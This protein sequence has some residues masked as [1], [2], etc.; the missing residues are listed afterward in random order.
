MAQYTPLQLTALAQLMQNQ[1]LRTLPTALTTAI[2][3]YNATAVI[4]D[5]L[6][7]VVWYKQQSFFTEST[8]DALLS[9]GSGV[10]P[11]LGNS[12]PTSPLG[13]FA[14]IIAKYITY[15]S[16]TGT[17]TVNPAGFADLLE[18]AGNAYLGNSNASN[19]AQNFT[20]VQGYVDSTNSV[21]NSAANANSYLGPTFKTMDSLVT[22]GISEVNSD[23][24]N[25]GTDLA[26]Q[27]NLV[28]PKNVANFG[29]PAALLQQLAKL[30]NMLNGSLPGVQ[31][32][33]NAAGLTN[34]DIADLV[35]N[36]VQSLFNPNGL[37]AYD[38]DIL[39]KKA[40]RG[41]INVTGSDLVDV[42][43][44]F[45][46]KT[47]GITTMADLLNP[48]K[49]FPLS[50]TTFATPDSSGN[51]VPVY[52]DNVGTINADIQPIVAANLPAAS[53]CEELGKVIPPDQ[54]VAN[55]ALQVSF[56]QIS[57]FPLTTWPALAQAVKGYTDRTWNPN[58]YYLANDVVSVNNG[59]VPTFYQAQQDVLPGVNIVDTNFWKPTT[60]PCGLN[61]MV[62]LPD[63][64]A[65]TT[66][67]PAS[68][69]Q[70]F[71]DNVATGSGANGTLTIYDIIGLAVDYNNFAN[72]L[73]TV[74]STINT[75]DGLG[76][77]NTLKST[78]LAIVTSVNDAAVLGY[79]ATAN[80][81]ISTIAAAQPAYVSAMNTA[82]VYMANLLNK[83]FG[84]QNDAGVDYFLDVPAISSNLRA[85]V[86][87]LNQYGTM[88]EPGGPAEFLNQ[89]ADTAT[90]GGQ[91]M[92]GSLRAGKNA[93]CLGR[94]RILTN[95]LTVPN[96]PE[97]DPI[98]AVTPE[99]YTKQ[100][101]VDAL[102]L[103]RWPGQL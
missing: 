97:L 19:F 16:T 80:A 52:A 17:S 36:N 11:A 14:D 61:T 95:A 43:T 55:K 62:D 18:Q 50:F 40:Y 99:T 102:R 65:Q 101:C 21:I 34:K 67:I 68:V 44:V 12:V 79:I 83:E 70:Y 42:L 59:S 5:W 33:L 53:G 15:D 84:Y 75:L 26:N 92:V 82:W 39:Q 86:Q 66:P 41:L 38:F 25:F 29:T 94:A 56:Q 81:D 4:A 46:V 31:N 57:G 93:A 77:L 9:I 98:P 71:A 51:P 64:Q 27:G 63:I 37:S 23:F 96:E 85:F 103:N 13:S 7:A 73:N 32:A 35:N 49:T 3:N 78:Y 91:A 24:D 45:G 6:A 74:T 22:A 58:Q 89:V 28:N 30:G 2:N 1:G 72:Q 48:V 20:S 54:A 10:C 60:L 69:Q 8:L 47:P 87:N 100:Q 90:L 88:N 76:A